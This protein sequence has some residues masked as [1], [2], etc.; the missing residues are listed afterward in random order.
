MKKDS[1][2]RL[3]EV[4]GRL[5]K[6]FKPVLNEWNF[7][8]KKDDDSDDKEE[9]EEKDEKPKGKTQFNFDKKEDKETEKHEDS[10]T[11]EEL[12]E[13]DAPKAKIP[14]NAIA[15]VG[16]KINESLPVDEKYN[17]WGQS[18]DAWADIENGKPSIGKE[19][20]K[21]VNLDKKGELGSGSGDSHVPEYYYSYDS[22]DPI[23]NVNGYTQRQIDAKNQQWRDNMS[24]NM[25]GS[26]G[27]EDGMYENKKIK[28]EK[29]KVRLFEVMQRVTP[30]FTGKALNERD[31]E[32][33]AQEKNAGDGNAYSNTNRYE[34]ENGQMIPVN[35]YD[36]FEHGKILGTYDSNGNKIGD[37]NL[38]KSIIEPKKEPTPDEITQTNDDSVK[39]TSAL[40][41]NGFF[42]SSGSSDKFVKP[43][44]QGPNW[45][46]WSEMD[47]FLKD[48]AQKGLWSEESARK[49]SENV[50]RSYD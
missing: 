35:K 16:G 4:M 14:V 48:G 11:P 23:S 12:K 10:E 31:E 46:G 24:R 36:E 49:Y 27:D 30:N 19:L 18:Q 28:L 3:F 50:W 43:Y 8:K 22:D 45:H 17:K 2:V 47:K 9:K 29:S 39:I 32:F 38:P 26:M 44:D 42:N 5:D 15:K 21:K 20:Q 1:K 6:T 13:E 41:Q 33:W 34:T 7:D 25:R 40:I 37:P